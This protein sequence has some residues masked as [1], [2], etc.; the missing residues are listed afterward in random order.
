MQY[1]SEA[2]K[3]SRGIVKFILK[4]RRKG[5]QPKWQEEELV[6]LNSEAYSFMGNEDVVLELS[7]SGLVVASADFGP[8]RYL[9]HTVSCLCLSPRVP[10]S[11]DSSLLQGCPGFWTWLPGILFFLPLRGFLR[12]LPFGS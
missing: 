3:D 12:C 10:G 1:Q 2:L 4:L 6:F 11:S 9:E 8:H 5:N 7:F